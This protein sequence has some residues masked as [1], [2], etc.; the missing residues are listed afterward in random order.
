MVKKRK[1]PRI[2]SP[3]KPIYV[4]QIQFSAWGAYGGCDGFGCQGAN[5]TGYKHRPDILSSPWAVDK[6]LSKMEIYHSHLIQPWS[7][8]IHLLNLTFFLKK[9]EDYQKIAEILIDRLIVGKAAN[10]TTSPESF[11]QD[12]YKLKS[13]YHGFNDSWKLA[14]GLTF[15]TNPLPTGGQ[16]HTFA[17]NLS[18]SVPFSTYTGGQSNEFEESRGE[19]TNPRIPSEDSSENE[20]GSS[21]RLSKKVGLGI[22][23]DVGTIF[24]SPEKG[25]K[26]SYCSVE[27]LENICHGMTINDWNGLIEELKKVTSNIKCS[28]FGYIWF[29]VGITADTIHNKWDTIHGRCKT[30]V[31]EYKVDDT[32]KPTRVDI[33]N[34]NSNRYLLVEDLPR[35]GANFT[36]QLRDEK[37]NLC[38]NKLNYIFSGDPSSFDTFMKNELT[39]FVDFVERNTDGFLGVRKNCPLSGWDEF[40]NRYPVY[41]T[42]WKDA[43]NVARYLD[44]HQYPNPVSFTENLDNSCSNNQPLFYNPINLL[45]LD[46]STFA[47]SD[48]ERIY[49]F[50]FLMKHRYPYPFFLVIEGVNH[51]YN[52]P[53]SI[54]V[55][56]EKVNHCE[57]LDLDLLNALAETAKRIF[58]KDD[59]ILKMNNP[60][61]RPIDKSNSHSSISEEL[62]YLGSSKITNPE[63]SA[64][65]FSDVLSN[66]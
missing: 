14:D 9:P 52:P 28:R 7:F 24:N 50:D 54:L 56:P 65:D 48:E 55:P 35:R 21:P 63:N 27:I 31:K 30:K 11:F 6:P 19:T 46:R 8:K 43:Y 23:G 34:P 44:Y 22:R 45:P 18:I 36:F 37:A 49:I 62:P 13:R 40:T 5:C 29:G 38:W 64:K 3:K 60:Y 20:G 12:A 41:K 53:I 32:D 4:N 15:A 58:N 25:A 1:I 42:T 33:G 47:I 39:N 57:Y 66:E 51:Y 61:S 59:Y 26:A 16:T 2:S 17:D 10:K